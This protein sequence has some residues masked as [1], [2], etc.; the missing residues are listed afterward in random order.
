MKDL[1]RKYPL[2]YVGRSWSHLIAHFSLC[3][4]LVR[5]GNV[6]SNWMNTDYTISDRWDSLN[7]DLCIQSKKKHW[8]ILQ[9]IHPDIFLF[10]MDIVWG[11]KMYIVST[12]FNRLC[13]RNEKD[14]HF[15]WIESVLW[16]ETT[17]HTTVRWVT[18]SFKTFFFFYIFC[19]LLAPFG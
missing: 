1:S 2:H 12:Y 4:Y 13:W 10:F 8:V 16:L 9:K 6:K 18:A 14:T 17:L 5:L 7:I 19:S 11:I 3:R 15:C